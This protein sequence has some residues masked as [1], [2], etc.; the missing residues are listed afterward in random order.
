MQ[1]LNSDQYARLADVAHRYW[2]VHASWFKSSP[3]R[4]PLLGVDTLCF[5][6]WSGDGMGQDEV[7]LN[8]EPSLVG[9]LL[10]PISLS[11]VLLPPTSATREAVA[12]RIVQLP[13]GA[14]AFNQEQV[15]HDVWFWRCE[16]L[17]DLGDI[18]SLQEGSR[19]AQQLVS[20][21][22]DPPGAKA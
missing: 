8:D 17:S 21:V 20:R 6:P 10:T 12:E 11:L 16:V 4:N 19:L 9:A 5:R 2:Q 1:A 22:M 15:D 14:Y 13:G 18:D 3:C 7:G